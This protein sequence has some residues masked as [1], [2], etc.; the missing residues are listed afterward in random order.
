MKLNYLVNSIIKLTEIQILKN[1]DYS[2]I[3]TLRESWRNSNIIYADANICT[4]IIL[5]NAQAQ[6]AEI[7]T[8]DHNNYDV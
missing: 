4:Y 3:N 7:L 5:K 8:V 1:L 6:Q 2:K